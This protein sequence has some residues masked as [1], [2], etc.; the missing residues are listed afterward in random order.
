MLCNTFWCHY[1]FSLYTFLRIKWFGEAGVYV[2]RFL[3]YGWPQRRRT[4]LP[5][6][7][8]LLECQFHRNA[9]HNKTILTME[10]GKRSIR[11]HYRKQIMCSNCYVYVIDH[12][13]FK[14][15]LTL[16]TAARLVPLDS[17]HFFSSVDL[18]HGKMFQL[19]LG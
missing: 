5:F 3:F 19:L 11:D 12:F 4:A 16:W 1:V 9:K 18:R 15:L 13:N 14:C 7:S 6:P 17:G 10:Q 2:L 8:F